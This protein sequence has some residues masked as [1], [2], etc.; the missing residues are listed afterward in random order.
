MLYLAVL[1][2]WTLNC[3]SLA[4]CHSQ[5][6]DSLNFVGKKVKKCPA[7]PKPIHWVYFLV[8]PGALEDMN[9]VQ[10]QAYV[11]ICLFAILSQTATALHIYFGL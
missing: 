8:L 5:L 4:F 1:W 3:L 6:K 11:S 7:I 10:V 2:P 9:D